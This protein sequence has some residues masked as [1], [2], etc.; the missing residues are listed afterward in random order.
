MKNEQQLHAKQLEEK[1]E[2]S[3]KDL[4]TQYEKILGLKDKELNE[5]HERLQ[6]VT[7]VQKNGSADEEQQRHIEGYEVCV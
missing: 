4:Q 2:A 6:A 7:A 1:H 3:F 5:A